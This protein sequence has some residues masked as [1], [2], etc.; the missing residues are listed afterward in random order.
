M[1]GNAMAYHTTS[2]QLVESVFVFF[3][4]RYT[5]MECLY[6]CQ[7]SYSTLRYFNQT[8]YRQLNT[9][10]FWNDPMWIWWLNTS[11]VLNMWLQAKQHAGFGKAQCMML[12]RYERD[13]MDISMMTT[14]DFDGV[15]DKPF[16]FFVLSVYWSYFWPF[17]FC[18]F[19]KKSRSTLE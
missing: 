18:L 16:R 19:L 7:L 3:A 12:D 8:L 13:V 15:S 5:H 9:I 17:P 14:Q 1:H 10:A 6:L 2:S 11:R 4:G